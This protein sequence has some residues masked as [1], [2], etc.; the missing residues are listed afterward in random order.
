MELIRPDD[1]LRKGDVGEA[2]E[3]LQQA[4]MAAG[5]LAEDEDDGWF[6]ERT[7]EAVRA[8]QRAQDL[9]V[10]GLAGPKTRSALMGDPLPATLRQSDLA[11][12]ADTLGVELAVLMAVNEVESRGRGFLPGTGRAVILYERHVMYRRLDHHGLNADEAMATWPNLVNTRPGG[13]TGGE[14]EYDR[15]DR[16]RDIDVTSALESASWG[17][18]QIM[19]FNWQRLGYADVQAYV[20]A[21]QSGESAQ[22]DAFVRFIQTDDRLQNALEA[23][24]FETF[25]RLYNGPDYADNGYHTRLATAYRRH[26]R[27]LSRTA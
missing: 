27:K 17:A 9:V 25:A 18:F 4:L 21:M 1:I 10:D 2:I 20:D 8:Y 22:L 5:H 11:E 16:A 6:G 15:L 7:E 3:H 14:A 19:G 13:Y 24:D 12:A 23:A 26:D